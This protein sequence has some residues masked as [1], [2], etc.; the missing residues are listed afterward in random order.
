MIIDHERRFWSELGMWDWQWAAL[1]V[2]LSLWRNWSLESTHFIIYASKPQAYVRDVLRSSAR[3]ASELSV[4]ISGELDGNYTLGDLVLSRPLHRLH[5]QHASYD[6]YAFPHTM[7]LASGVWAHLQD[8]AVL[9]LDRIIVPLAWLTAASKLRC[10]HL[11]WLPWRVRNVN[12]LPRIDVVEF[13]QLVDGFKGL[14]ELH[15][16]GAFGRGDANGYRA[17]VPRLRDLRVAGYGRDVGLMLAGIEVGGVTKLDVDIRSDVH[18]ASVLMEVGN[19][20]R[21]WGVRTAELV[22]MRWEDYGD[23]AHIVTMKLGSA[24]SSSPA[25]DAW[26][27]VMVRERMDTGKDMALSLVRTLETLEPTDVEELKV[28]SLPKTEVDEEAWKRILKLCLRTRRVE[29]KWP[30]SQPGSHPGSE[31]HPMTRVFTTCDEPSVW[32]NLEVVCL[33]GGRDE[34]DAMKWLTALRRRESLLG[35]D[36]PDVALPGWVD[37]DQRAL[38]VLRE[39]G[40]LDVGVRLEVSRNRW[41]TEDPESVGWGTGG[42][43]N[44]GWGTESIG[45]GTESARWSTEIVG[46]GT[47]SVGLGTGSVGWG[48]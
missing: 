27:K 17:N 47:E 3:V 18:D 20:A 21:N 43:G 25:T 9:K 39:K 42:T 5:I 40:H 2:E 30:W 10:V 15:V 13:I 6:P 24:G 12:H 14:E 29:L 19:W 32:P 8:L 41:S 11:S 23:R 31:L 16:E 4:A 37:E 36:N 1:C 44:D 48:T 38:S 45:W 22:M 26:C 28:G 33:D 7:S 35:G 46:W 34:K